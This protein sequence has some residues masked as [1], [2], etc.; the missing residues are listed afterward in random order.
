MYIA[1]FFKR[2][3]NKNCD[4]RQV[5]YLQASLDLRSIRPDPYSGK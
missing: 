5:V 1:R 2:T 3:D 4:D